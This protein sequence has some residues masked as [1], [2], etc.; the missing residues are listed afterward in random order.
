M[1]IKVLYIGNA[2]LREHP[3]VSGR[4]ISQVRIIPSLEGRGAKTAPKPDR[5]DAHQRE[6]AS[7]SAA[8]PTKGGAKVKRLFSLRSPRARVSKDVSSGLARGPRAAEEP[9]VGRM[10]ATEDTRERS[11]KPPWSAWATPVGTTRG[12][13]GS[14]RAT[15]AFGRRFCATSSL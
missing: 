6:L 14:G 11:R 1:S 13:E 3:I 2:C 7:T 5:C 12:Y 15:K 10:D 9:R 8:A 4:S